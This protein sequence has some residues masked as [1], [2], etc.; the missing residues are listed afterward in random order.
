MGTARTFQNFGAETDPA[1]NAPAAVTSTASSGTAPTNGSQLRFRSRA[2]DKDTDQT[3]HLYFYLGAD[4]YSGGS[5]VFKYLTT[6]TA[7]A[8]VWK[9]ASVLV[10][11]AS[12]GSPTD[13][14]A[15][16]FGTVTAATA[17]TVPSTAGQTKEMS[18]D[19]G[20]SGAHG[21]DLLVV[22]LGRDA[23][24]AADNAAASALLLEPWYLTYTTV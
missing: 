23:D 1:A 13:L 15:A 17:S 6:V 24:N 14:D 20:L 12:E 10:H 22:M 11:P 4:Y 18:I 19:L 8:V 5:L 3:L 21:G 2:F 7:N 9:T 16:V